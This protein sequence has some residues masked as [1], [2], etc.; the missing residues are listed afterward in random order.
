M[1]PLPPSAREDHPRK[2]LVGLAVALSVVAF[3]TFS[4]VLWN[5]FISIDDPQYVVENAWVRQ[6]LTW[7]AVVWAFTEFH[8]GWWH[9]ITTL[10]HMLDVSLWGLAPG[11]HHLTSL[12]VHVTNGCVLF[13]LLYRLGLEPVRAFLASAL[14]TLHPTRVES[15]AWLSERKDL[16][17][18]LFFL[19]A[20]WAYVQFR[21]RPTLSRY[22]LVGLLFALGL[23]S[24]SMLVSFPVLLLFVDLWLDRGKVAWR[25]RLLEKLPLLALSLVSV[26]LT[27][28][29]QGSIGAVSQASDASGFALRVWAAG[30][31]YTAYLWKTVAPLDLCILYPLRPVGLTEGLLSWALVLGTSAALWRAR[32]R[33]PFALAGWLWF[34]LSLGPVLGVVQAG[35]QFIADRYLYLPH[36]G[37]FVGAVQAFPPGWASRFRLLPRALAGGVLLWLSLLSFIQTE[38]WKD[39]VSVFEQALRVE[40][41]NPSMSLSYGFYLSRQG[42]EPEAESQF[43]LAAPYQPRAAAFVAYSLL[44]RGKLTEALAAAQEAVDRFPQSAHTRAAL[45]IVLNAQ[46][47]RTE[48]LEHLR[49]AVANPAPEI[50]FQVNLALALAEAGA[51]AEAGQLLDRAL[52]RAPQTAGVLLNL[53]DAFAKVGQVP[54]AI[55]ILERLVAVAP[56]LDEPRRL[57]ER[58]R[59]RSTPD[60]PSQAP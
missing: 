52:A 50:E 6:G 58:L 4:G 49:V 56:D 47:R 9:P 39:P 42:K 23:M 24:K 27:V 25:R 3:G 43:R 30:A 29:A 36:V 5:G 28:K 2:R 33:A 48:A 51:R 17:F 40:P 16:L 38:T 1:R 37:L 14:V 26:G 53:A 11:G 7:K 19:L 18:M 31:K 12:L 10:T 59:S 35:S 60:E 44:S 57:L 46:G 41:V 32:H 15:V 34:L 54:Q 8:F 22:A 21:R 13:I 20:T 55:A 45:G